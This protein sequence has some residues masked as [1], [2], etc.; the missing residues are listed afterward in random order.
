MHLQV[1][2]MKKYLFVLLLISYINSF[3]QEVFTPKKIQL[4]GYIKTMQSWQFPDYPNIYSNHLLHN[5]MNLKWQPHS[6]ISVSA[7]W[8]NRIISGDEVRMFPNYVSLLK[9]VNEKWNAS[10]IWANSKDMVVITNTERF[11]VSYKKNKWF[12]RAGRQRIN[13]STTTTWNPNDIF[14]S[15]NFLD[16]DYEERP[17]CD[18]LQTRYLINDKS[19][20]ELALAFAGKSGKGISALKYFT[21]IK[22]WDLQL[23]GGLY[24]EKITLGGSWAKS[25]RGAGWKGEWQ[26]FHE[27]PHG[28]FNFSTELDYLFKNNWYVKTGILYN[29]MGLS[30]KVPNRQQLEFKMTPLMQMPAAWNIESMAMR[31]FNA[32]IKASMIIIYAPVTKILIL[33]PVCTFSI[34]DNTDADII[35]QQ[36][37]LQEKTWNVVQQNGFLRI[38]W[39]F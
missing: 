21:Q 10:V 4:N 13:W 14:N 27:S 19:N 30:G 33:V 18:A 36:F 8:R 15:Y 29:S 17:G 24:D 38:K 26:Y 11:W 32:V 2:K 3:G 12:V 16:F 35:L 23:I 37:F 34:S 6:A 5:R 39:S 9:N 1:N 28:V 25:I 20:L 7:E 31:E 22:N